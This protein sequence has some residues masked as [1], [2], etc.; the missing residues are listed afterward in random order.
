M[1]DLLQQ[2]T[3]SKFKMEGRLQIVVR[4]ASGRPTYFWAQPNKI[5]FGA[6]D[7]VLALL[8]QRTADYPGGLPAQIANDQIYSMRMGT[9]A[10]PAQRS[11]QNLGV[12]IIGK[13]IGNANK[14]TTI[15]GEVAFVTTLETTDA[16]G[17][18]LQEA[19]L[20]TRG[21]GTGAMDAPGISVVTPRLFAR[22][23]H[24]PIPKTNAISLEYTWRI[25]MTA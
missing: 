10:T 12:P 7:V 23:A 13:V 17:F 14:I 20:F 25:A 1:T 15:P 6:A 24:P 5:V 16:N 3:Q 4:D 8:C 22:Q 9:S 21:S 18:T 19:G 2:S 11:D